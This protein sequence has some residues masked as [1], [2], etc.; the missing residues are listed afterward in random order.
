MKIKVIDTQTL[1]STI[2]NQSG[3]TLEQAVDLMKQEV[4]GF[5]ANAEIECGPE[6][7]LFRVGRF[8]GFILY[9]GVEPRELK[10]RGR[11]SMDWSDTI[12][13]YNKFYKPELTA[14]ELAVI[15]GISLGHV[16]YVSKMVNK[17]LKAAK[18]GR[19]H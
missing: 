1:T 12:E 17:P 7:D 8:I 19:K 14:K 16:Y 15:S 3:I 5:D 6:D 9:R 11:S 4:P 13:L 10:A 18:R 2:V